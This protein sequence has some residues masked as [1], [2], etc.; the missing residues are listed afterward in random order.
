M[1]FKTP[2]ATMINVILVPKQRELTKTALHNEMVRVSC[3]TM[4][5]SATNYER[6]IVNQYMLLK[7]LS[8]ISRLTV[9]H[10]IQSITK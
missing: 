8:A 5:F 4:V 3:I 7:Y 10:T 9:H 6:V 2:T 1:S